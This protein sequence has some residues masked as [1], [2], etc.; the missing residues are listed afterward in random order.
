M[1]QWPRAAIL[2]EIVVSLGSAWRTNSAVC[3]LVAGLVGFVAYQDL[4]TGVEQVRR[5]RTQIAVGRHTVL[6]ASTEPGEAT[7]DAATCRNLNQL[8]QVSAAGSLR[9]LGA[10]EVASHPSTFFRLY[11]ADGAVHRALDP[12]STLDG[13]NSVSARLTTQLGLQPG[14][15]LRLSISNLDETTTTKSPGSPFNPG[16]RHEFGDIMWLVHKPLLLADECWIDFRESSSLDE[17]AI[18]R[19]AFAGEAQVAIRMRRTEAEIGPS[20]AS[21]FNQRATAGNHLWFGGFA[22][23]QVCVGLWFQRSRASLYRSLGLSRKAV[24]ASFFAEGAWISCLSSLLGF[25]LALRI[26]AAEAD[27]ST[28]DV[29]QP[30][31]GGIVEFLAGTLGLVAVGCVILASG[32][33]L[34]Q[35]KER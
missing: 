12:T 20:P 33:I 29:V 10:A 24:A 13:A 17:A 1:S 3:L 21:A 32:N 4:S 8:E 25:L 14:A 19:A 28:A 9:F 22:G 5:E 27:L 35:L 11:S 2:R 23:L 7:I 16:L 31:F 30:A 18:V 26:A 34:E 6:V 15:L